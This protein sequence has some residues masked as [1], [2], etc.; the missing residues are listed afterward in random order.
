M[1]KKNVSK[2]V[3]GIAIVALAMFLIFRLTGNKEI[4]GEE[5]EVKEGD[6]S[7]YYNFSGS[8]EAKNKS[9]IFAELPLQVSEFLVEKGEKVEKGDVIY[10]SS[11]GQ[12]VKA[13]ISGEISKIGVEENAQISPGTEIIE[14]VDYNEL[15][16]KVKVD[17]YDLNSIKVGTKVEVTVNALDK[18]FKG[19]IVDISK[20]GVYM[21]GV[22]FFETLISVE[23]EEGIRVG[24][25]AEAKVLNEESNNTKI[26]PMNSIEFRNDNTPYVNIKK[27]KSVK[28]KEI[29][30]GITDGVNVEIKSGLEIGDK[31][32]I[33]KVETNNFGPPEG[34]RRSDDSEVNK[35]E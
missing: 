4:Q 21:N 6:I 19:E 5:I 7:T 34:V 30:I 14:I 3:I 10:K 11:T 33:P 28:E 13:D 1:N 24:M 31:V 22:T 20:Q 27:D 15:E 35:D 16:L 32:F 18:I 23:S 17:E 2:W 9:T 25:S 29:E 8:I 12:N 26:L